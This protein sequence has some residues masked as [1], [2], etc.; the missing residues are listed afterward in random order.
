MNWFGK[1][2]DPSPPTTTARSTS[3]RTSAADTIIKI[4]EQIEAQE[5]R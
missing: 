3:A 1:K 2:K 5:K 4:G